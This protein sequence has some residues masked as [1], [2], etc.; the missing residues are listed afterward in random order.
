MNE[1]R[2]AKHTVSLYQGLCYL[3]V[4]LWT[5]LCCC[6]SPGNLELPSSQTKWGWG[7]QDPLISLVITAQGTGFR[8]HSINGSTSK[9]TRR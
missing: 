5:T 9:Q 2:G 1:I 3:A 6:L 8:R 7:D 4:Y